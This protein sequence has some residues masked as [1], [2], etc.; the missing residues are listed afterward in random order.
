MVYF[1]RQK[2]YTVEATEKYLADAPYGKVKR[3]RSEIGGEFINY[4]FKS[5]K[6]SAPYSPHQNGTVERARRRLFSMARCLLLDAKFPKYLWT[7]AVIASVFIRNTC[8]NPRLGKTP[9]E[10]LIGKQPNLSNMHVFGSTCC[11]FIQNAKKLEARS[12]KGIFIGYDNGSPAYLVFY[13]ETN[14][15]QKVRRVKF[16]DNFQAVKDD[17]GDVILNRGK[18]ED[19]DKPKIPSIVDEQQN[20][21]EVETD[22]T[23]DTHEQHEQ[24]NHAKVLNK[25]E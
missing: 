21:P 1:L 25:T 9:Y 19:T 14:K 5:L 22:N 12:Q 4:K 23:A 16:I 18:G 6:T 15:V 10:A 17:Q 8:F 11:A 24:D 13:P 7:F 2:S 20:I 3:M